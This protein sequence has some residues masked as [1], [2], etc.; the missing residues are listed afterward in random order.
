M[1]A[2]LFA[3][4][5]CTMSRRKQ[6][7]PQHIDSDEPAS[8]GNGKFYAQDMRVGLLKRKK[9]KKKKLVAPAMPSQ[10]HFM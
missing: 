7:K 2:T 4:D 3:P 5:G 6:A 9:E 8:I 1:F 10:R